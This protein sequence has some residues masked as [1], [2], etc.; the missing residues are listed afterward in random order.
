[1]TLQPF[2]QHD[3][4]D[5]VS[6]Y[7]NDQ[8]I[9]YLK[10]FLNQQRLM[11]L[12]Q[13][14][15]QMHTDAEIDLQNNW[16]NQKICFYSKN[17]QNQHNEKS[18]EY[19]TQPYFLTS[20]D[21]THVFY[22]MI[23]NVCAVNRIGHGMHLSDQ[24]KTLQS[25]VYDNTWLNTLLQMTGHIKPICQLS[26]YIPKHPNEIGSDVRPHQESTFAYT[27][28]QSVVVLW[29]AL[30]DALISNACMWG[31]PGSHTW[32][33]KYVS[34]VNHQAKTRLF[35]T[36][37]DIVIPDFE[38]DRN[39]FIPLEVSA[40][41]ALLFHGN[42]IHCSPINKS[43]L[44]RQALSLQFIETDNTHYPSTNWLQPP[45]TKYLFDLKQNQ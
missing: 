34:R 28:P 6:S 30:E 27:E 35:E 11:S 40:G 2:T 16:N 37:N 13:D 32:P 19:V 8:G 20:K 14:I 12:L 4:L 45:N 42:F 17:P 18:T 38:C 43:S 15:K 21:K 23:D 5:T 26:V 1:M 41:D 3:S 24:Y 33:L 39:Q 10:E 25:I 36:I 29:I 31:I 9:I 44:S 22:E 7:Y